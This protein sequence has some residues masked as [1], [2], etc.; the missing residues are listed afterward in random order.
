MINLDSNIVAVSLPS[1]ARSLKADFAGIEWVISA[2]TLTFASLVLPAGALADRYGRK[3]MLVIGLGI[4]TFASVVCGAAPNVGVLNAARAVQGVGAAIQLSAALATLSHVFRGPARARAFAFWG[5]VIGIAISLGPIAGGVI[6]QVAGWEWAFYVNVPVG[7]VM[8]AMTL[9]AVEESCDPDAK[10]MDILGF[11]TFSAALSLITLAL[12]SG[13]RHGWTSGD[14]LLEAGSSVMLFAGFL[15]AESMQERP[16]LDLALF[17]RRTYLGANIA[18][19]AFAMALLTMLT[20]LPIY[21]QSGLGYGPQAAGLLM[22][23]MAVPLFLVPRIV[24]AALTHRLSGRALLT[25]GL[26]LVALGLLWMAFE[27]NRFDYRAM[28]GGMLIAG[29]GAGILN[30]ETAKVGMTVVTPERAGM[31][32]GV[33][34]TVRFSGIVIGFAALGAILFSRVSA[35]VFGALRDAPQVA[36]LS[37]VRRVMAGD[38]T[39]AYDGV[40]PNAVLHDLASRSFGAGYQAILLVASAIAAIAAILSWLLVGSAETAPVQRFIRDSMPE[41]MPVE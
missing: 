29:T 28:L 18:A 16:M 14:V 4:F 32:S 10:R 34:G 38:L 17:R 26:G 25:M 15:A 36:R 37:L 9:Y 3:R 20:Y 22:L 24:A 31:A 35:S 40:A 13:N 41:Q 2:Y 21:F 30:G 12:I 19:L 6:T 33:A 11:I 39:G 1:I 23:P 27:A 8:I 5:S 7:A